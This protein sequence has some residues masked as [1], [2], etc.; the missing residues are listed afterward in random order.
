MNI[1]EVFG[2]VLRSHRNK[3]GFSQEILALKS[4]LDRTY[5]SMLERGKRKPT[6]N[7]VFAIAEILNVKPSKLIEEIE[8]MLEDQD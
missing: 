4:G 8:G 5:I 6:I 3:N 2:L 7:T 1:E